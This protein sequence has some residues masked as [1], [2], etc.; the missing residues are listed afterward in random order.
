MIIY[1]KNKAVILRFE[2]NIEIE[3]IVDIIINK[4]YLDILEHPKKDGQQIF[5]LEY[6]NYT[7]VVPFVIDNEDNIIIK[8]VFPSRN[9]HK[10]Y[11]EKLKWIMN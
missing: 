7:H 3:D 6:R 2:R 9:F 10:I 11:K 8:T 1:D 5:I 4:K